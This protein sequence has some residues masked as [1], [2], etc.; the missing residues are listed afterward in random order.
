VYITQAATTTTISASA[1]PI[2][3]GQATTLTA[4]VQPGT[5]NTATGTITFVDNGNNI[6]TATLSN[7]VAHITVSNLSVGSHALGAQYGGDSTFAGSTSNYVLENV[8]QGPVSVTE[9]VSANPSTWGQS[10]TFTANVAPTQATTTPTGFVVFVDGS[11]NLVS[12]PLVNGSAQYSVST[13]NA[14]AHSILAKYSGDT[15]Y[16]AGTSP[17]V[18]Q[19]VTQ[20][21]TTTMLSTDQN[22]SSFNQQQSPS[23][24]ARN[25]T[26]AISL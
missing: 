26:T 16:L 10:V 12:V 20:A 21:A 9:T 3:F 15:N 23:A 1:N 4:T 22:P 17:A 24:Q 19:N 7:N 14:G 13:L 2:N 5:G 11:S 25:P 8:N 6:G 18:A